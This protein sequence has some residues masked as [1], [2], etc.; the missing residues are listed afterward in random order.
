MVKNMKPKIFYYKY[1]LDLNFLGYLD[2]QEIKQ[3]LSAMF[4]LLNTEQNE[5]DLD[6]ISQKILTSLDFSNDG[7]VS[8]GN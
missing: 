7:K 1:F 4:S 8:K 6:S 3:V 5:H 2:K